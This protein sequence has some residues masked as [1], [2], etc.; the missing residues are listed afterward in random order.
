MLSYFL[1]KTCVYHVNWA[2]SPV[3]KNINKYIINRV[4]TS[5]IQLQ[6]QLFLFIYLFDNLRT[7]DTEYIYI[8]YILPTKTNLILNK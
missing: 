1:F 2:R 8:M 4:A 3:N 5:L 7:M 6:Y